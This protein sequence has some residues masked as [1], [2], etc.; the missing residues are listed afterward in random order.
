[1]HSGPGTFLDFPDGKHAYLENISR[2]KSVYLEQSEQG[3][4][5][6]DISHKVELGTKSFRFL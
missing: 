4:V 3:K 1:M 5:Q 2:G 6:N